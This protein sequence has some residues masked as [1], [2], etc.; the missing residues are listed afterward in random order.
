MIYILILILG[1]LLSIWTPWWII[2][3]AVWGICWWKKSVNITLVILQSSGAV[4]TL[5]LG[6][7][8][9]ICLKAETIL[10]HRIASILQSKELLVTATSDF[11]LIIG[12]TFLIASVLGGL[13]GYAG[14]KMKS[15]L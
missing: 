3:L 7:I 4:A 1:G 14:Y 11:A 8:L 15:L 13:S 9:F 12:V 2:F 6:Y 10:F 5:W